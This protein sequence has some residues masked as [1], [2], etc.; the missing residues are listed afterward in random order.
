MKLITFSDIPRSTLAC[1]LDVAGKAR[2]ISPRLLMGEPSDPDR[3]QLSELYAGGFIELPDKPVTNLTPAFAKAAQVLLDPHTN[4]TFRIW[5][6]DNICGETN[7]QFPRDIILGNGVMLNQVGRMYRISAFVD[8]S[9]VTK[10]IKDAIPAPREVNIDFDFK[11]QFESPVAAIL[12]AVIDLARIQ[13]RSAAKQAVSVSDA[14][15]SSQQIYNYMF[16]RWSLT[17]F[18]DFITYVTAV[19]MMA[20][21]PSLSQTAD[22]LRLLVKGGVLKENKKDYYSLIPGLEPL[23]KLTVG[24]QSGVQW[25][26]ISLMDS[27]DVIVSNRM[28]LFGDKSLMLCLAPTSQGK[29]FISRVKRQEIIDFLLDEITAS[30]QPSPDKAPV[31]RPTTIPAPRPSTM[32][33]PRPTSIPTTVPAAAPVAPVA[34]CTQCGAALRPNAK[35]CSKCGAA[36]VKA[37]SATSTCSNCG[38][39]LKPNAKFC[40][41]CGSVVAGQAQAQSVQNTCPNCGRQLKSGAKFC[42]GCGTQI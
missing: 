8:D 18:K 2:G 20:E 9:D 4:L 37:A 12:F 5:G 11:A 10:L 21:P 15:F 19:G 31:P 35:H 16:D 41:K 1:L 25:Q 32:P 26:R 6:K 30:L 7:I 36:V 29:L 40:A 17:G 3:H 24:L 33:A 42:A 22:G 39:G 27:G 23:V 28:Y 38:A 14:V 34:S 13:A